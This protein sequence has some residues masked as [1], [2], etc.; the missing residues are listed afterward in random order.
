[1]YLT[2]ADPPATLSPK[3]LAQQ[4]TKDELRKL[5]YKEWQEVIPAIYELAW[6]LREFGDLII[7]CNGEQVP[8]DVMFYEVKAPI[9]IMRREL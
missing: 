1:M 5:G 9:K 2:T 7:F 6:E 3:R 8:D 4:F